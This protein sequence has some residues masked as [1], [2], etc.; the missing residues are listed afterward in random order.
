M[1]S[2]IFVFLKIIPE[3][4]PYNLSPLLNKIFT[5]IDPHR[6]C[7]CCLLKDLFDRMME[8]PENI[9]GMNPVKP[10]LDGNLFV[11]TM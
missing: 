5:I 6:I 9:I 11:I 8:P 7:L 1:S 4:I 3:N 10:L 2:A